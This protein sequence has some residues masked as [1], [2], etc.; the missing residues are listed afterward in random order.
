MKDF[1]RFNIGDP[2]S[3]E[4][5]NSLVDYAGV[6][7]SHVP[8]VPGTFFGSQRAN[9]TTEYN[10]PQPILVY[11]TEDFAT[12][13]TDHSIADDCPS[14][15]CQ[16]VR[17][18]RSTNTHDN[19]VGGRPFYVHDPVAGIMVTSSKAT[20]DVFH[21][22]WNR[23]CKRW[24]VINATSSLRLITAVILSC[25]GDGWHE[26]ELTDWN[27]QPDTAVASSSVS[28]SGSDTSGCDV[29][30]YVDNTDSSCETITDVFIDRDVG[31]P[32]GEVVYAHTTHLMPMLVGGMIKMLKRA[33]MAA[34]ASASASDD[35]ITDRLYD[36][37]DGV[38]P[39][40]ALPFPQFECCVDPVTGATTVEVV[41]CSRVVVEG[42]ECPEEPT[43]CPT[44]SGSA[45]V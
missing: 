15:L 16:F 12:Q 45:S 34:S 21:A 5:M 36:V 19:V 14:G 44:G 17:L 41:A 20:G 29:C 13:T 39:L 33:P 9:A 32:T 3:A 8:Q 18:T 7:S 31:V 25:L 27:S 1:P 43:P 37:V 35:I 40:L 24:E 30:V 42:Y 26:V 10:A 23:D 6:A 28:T 22:I 4:K 38:W 11:A 2:I